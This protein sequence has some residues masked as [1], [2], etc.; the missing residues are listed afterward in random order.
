MDRERCADEIVLESLTLR[1]DP[2]SIVTVHQTRHA[3]TVVVDR[4]CMH[5]ASQ[6]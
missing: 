2:P 6:A 5:L 4:E 3:C 1:F